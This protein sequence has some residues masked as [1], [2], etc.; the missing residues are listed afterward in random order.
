[1]S[2]ASRQFSAPR[3]MP[4]TG[5]RDDPGPVPFISKLII[6]GT[7][8]KVA[9]DV[10][11]AGRRFELWSPNSRGLPFYPGIKTP[12]VDL[13]DLAQGKKRYD[14][15][16]GPLDP[17]YHPQHY[18]LWRSYLPMSQ[19]RPLVLSEGELVGHVRRLPSTVPLAGSL[20]LSNRQGYQ[21]PSLRSEDFTP[22]PVKLVELESRPFTLVALWSNVNGLDTD[23][24]P[25]LNAPPA[26]V[27]AATEAK[28][29]RRQSPSLSLSD[30]ESD[31]T[32]EHPAAGTKGVLHQGPSA[33]PAVQL[34]DEG[35]HPVASSSTLSDKTKR[36][37]EIYAASPF[38]ISEFW[39]IDGLPRNCLTAL[40]LLALL[41]EVAKKMLFA[42]RQ[43]LHM[44][45]RWEAVYWV[46]F[47]SKDQALQ[48]RGYLSSANLSGTDG[49]EGPLVAESTYLLAVEEVHHPK[50]RPLSPTGHWNLPID[51][52]ARFAGESVAAPSSL[53]LP[54][55]STSAPP[56]AP[57][58]PESMN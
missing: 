37:K 48:V 46:C 49:C 8:P 39:R 25:A 17:T 28:G 21:L 2:D 51:I 7:S 9:Q 52:D 13:E 53:E 20:S 41:K 16:L 5:Y 30:Y 19:L 43:V 18:Q 32:P 55:P 6:P 29:K 50:E 34:R 38:V 47:E 33:T 4:D 22:V 56:P 3:L 23:L 11:L 12:S 10:S 58:A 35:S 42:V 27:V 54:G 45:R 57:V 40:D 44:W 26:A 36:A 1:M 15:H 14:G 31:E 24:L